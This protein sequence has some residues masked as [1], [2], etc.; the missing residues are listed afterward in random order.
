MSAL[1][2]V[3][4]WACVRYDLPLS[5]I[6]GHRHYAST[7]CPGQH[8]GRL[9]A[10]GTIRRRVRRRIDAGGVSLRTVCGD[11]GDRLVARIGRGEL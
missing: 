6:R 11:A 4:A 5:R 9:I 2:D 10:D 1:V 3:L 7:S 8:L